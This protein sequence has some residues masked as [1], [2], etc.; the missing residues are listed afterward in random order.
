MGT[1]IHLQVER[2]N[3]GRWERVPHPLTECDTCEGTGK[4]WDWVPRVDAV[5]LE[6]VRET[7][8]DADKV[9]VR[10][11]KDCYWCKGTGKRREQ[12]WHS[13]NYNVFAI[14]ANVRNGYGFAGVDTGDALVPICEPRG[15][16]GDLSEEVRERLRETGNEVTLDDEGTLTLGYVEREDDEDVYGRL[17]ATEEGWWDL[18]DHSFS[19]LTL[20]ELADYDWS[21]VRESRGWVDP[22][23]FELWRKKGKPSSWSG[24][25]SGGSVEHI[26]NQQ[27]AEMID[28][29]DIQFV[30][31]DE[32]WENYDGIAY[33]R[34]YTSG[35]GRAMKEMGSFPQGSPGQAIAE[36]GLDR[37][38]HFT[39]VA[40]DTP[41]EETASEFLKVMRERVAPLAP[42]RDLSKI[43]IVFGFD[44]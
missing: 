39:L 30:G 44:S 10:M 8:H 7:P 22:W 15:I 9:G 3:E 25:V 17:E 38:S 13:R 6:V 41:Y 19:Y 31:D 4:D 2:Q 36:T 5:G 34:A 12:F 14:L 27:M 16:P 37:P 18:G 35:L 1:D 29:G 33:D 32:Q 24:G 42:D 23:N 43:R 21:R 11:D 20:Q 26:S 28:S 40:W